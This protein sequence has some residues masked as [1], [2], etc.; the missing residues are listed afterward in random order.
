MSAGRSGRRESARQRGGG[1][2]P[3]V[4]EVT[5][6][7]T[8]PVETGSAGAPGPFAIHLVHGAG[9]PPKLLREAAA[10]L[11]GHV[12]QGEVGIVVGAGF[13]DAAALRD[14][15]VPLLREAA[16]AG[17]T[18]AR[19][20]MTGGAVDRPDGPAPA[21]LLS[22]A[23]RIDVAAPRGLVL[24]GPDGT[25]F[26]PDLPDGT[27]GWWHF[28]P[29]HPPRRIGTRHPAPPW[30]AA[31]EHVEPA[32]VD[33]YAVEQIP[34]G[35][36]VLPAGTPSL[37]T[38]ALRYALPPLPGGPVVLVGAS[39]D[40]RVPADALAAVMAALPAP[41]RETARLVPGDGSDLL[42]LAQDTADLLD[43]PLQV[44]TGVP[45]LVDVSGGA[46][47]AGAEARVFV[48]DALGDPAWRPYVDAVTCVPSAS[49]PARAP[50]LGV[51][52]PPA[53]GLRAAL[54]PGTM[55]LDRKWQVVVTRS[56]LWIGPTGSTVPAET[57]TRPVD[58]EVMAVEIGL[59]DA[60]FDASLTEPMERLLA[61]LD[62]DMRGR[63]LV[64]VHGHG[65]SGEAA[66]ELRRIADRHGVALAPSGWLTGLTDGSSGAASLD[67]AESGRAE[68]GTADD[69]GSRARTPEHDAG[70][71]PCTGHPAADE[72]ASDD[73]VSADPVSA[74]PAPPPGDPEEWDGG[75]GPGEPPVT[76][77]PQA[78]AVTFTPPALAP[79]TDPVVPTFSA[80]GATAGSP[81]GSNRPTADGPSGPSGLP[82]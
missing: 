56:G 7:E 4:V 6:I 40:V 52:R 8:A 79:H 32:L 23:A 30:Q 11:G 14:R 57:A 13:E 67:T 45:L 70:A 82:E 63:T 64:R 38:A 18:T 78:V 51:W 22:D 74:T 17:V 10:Q 43:A 49:G 21:Q 20:V 34:A 54:E 39:R 71:S 5:T 16:E 77:R 36:L 66:E 72:P 62:E 55:L 61:G 37:S 35:L 73:P 31:A 44:S 48:T 41:V 2:G 65:S 47:E 26:A 68:S 81:S 3:A 46:T 60:P 19:L 80:E 53:D 50:R 1:N 29:D 75:N 33:G 42:P 12:L 25:L 28:S 59:A 9:R 58:P 15:L 24:I 76:T 27:G 69:A